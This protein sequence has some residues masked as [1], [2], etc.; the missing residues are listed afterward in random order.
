MFTSLFSVIAQSCTAGRAI[1]EHAF[2]ITVGRKVSNASYFVENAS[3][4]AELLISLSGMTYST[5]RSKSWD[6]EDGGDMFES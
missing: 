4:V 5:T 1:P 3:D 2:T 6:L